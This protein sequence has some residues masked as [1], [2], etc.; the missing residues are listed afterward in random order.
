MCVCV[1]VYDRSVCYQFT[2]KQ[3][4]EKLC[5]SGCQAGMRGMSAAAYSPL[6]SVHYLNMPL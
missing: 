5:L 3:Y 2:S 1:S 6:N 4:T